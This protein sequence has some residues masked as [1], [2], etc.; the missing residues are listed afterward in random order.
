M[1]SPAARELGPWSV[2]KAKL[3]GTCMLAWS[4]KYRAKIP[5]RPSAVTRIGV[6]AHTVLERMERG[7]GAETALAA[8]DKAHALTPEERAGVERLIGSMQSFMETLQS[9]RARTAITAELF[10]AKLGLSADLEPT[11]FFAADV[12]FRGAWDAAFVLASGTA[13]ILDHK[14][15]VRKDLKWHAAQLRS[16]AVMALAHYPE[17]R[18]VWP[19]IHFLGDAEVVWGAPALAEDIR[20]GMR[21]WF[22][23]WINEAAEKASQPDPQPTVSKF[24][25]VCGY[26]DRCPAHSLE[27][28]GERLITLSTR[29]RP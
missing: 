17:L 23:A 7:D 13:A 9:F 27:A 15:S 10:E 2:S 21:A 24:C 29:R 11:E 4:W 3:A 26:L 25:G 14:S 18:R 5:E 8:A 6:G 22:I 12:F 1:F 28:A 16:Y 19:A 20:G